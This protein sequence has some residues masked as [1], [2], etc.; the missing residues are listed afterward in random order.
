MCISSIRPQFDGFAIESKFMSISEK[1][2]W[3]LYCLSLFERKAGLIKN[4]RLAGN[5]VRTYPT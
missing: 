4:N 2:P 1:K 3:I 5:K